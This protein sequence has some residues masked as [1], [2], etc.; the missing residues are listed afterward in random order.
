[1]L[2]KTLRAAAFGMV[3][4][5]LALG[6]VG[7]LY[8]FFGLRIELDGGGQPHL[9]FVES[10]ESRAKIVARHREAQRAQFGMP[11][12]EEDYRNA[13]PWVDWRGCCVTEDIWTC[14]VC[15]HRWA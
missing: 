12:S 4:L 1:M 3:G 2:R 11:A 8:L 14:S 15:E 9:T 7:V 5:A 10:A 6:V 13:P